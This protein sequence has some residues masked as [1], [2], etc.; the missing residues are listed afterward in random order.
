MS[1]YGPDLF[2][3]LDS[4]QF[5]RLDSE[6]ARLEREFGIVLRPGVSNLPYANMQAQIKEAREIISSFSLSLMDTSLLIIKAKMVVPAGMKAMHTRCLAWL[7]A[8][9]E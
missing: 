7:K 9:R 5:E 4:E 2:P 1:E 3:T 8:N 6:L